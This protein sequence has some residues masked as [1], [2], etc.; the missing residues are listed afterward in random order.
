MHVYLNHSSDEANSE[1]KVEDLP[2]T[3]RGKEV[4]S[5]VAPTVEEFRQTY[6]SLGKT[7][8]EIVVLPISSHLS[9]TLLNAQVAA[10]Q[11]QGRLAVQ[12]ID[13]QTTSVGLG[14]LAQ[15][16]AEAAARQASL[17]EIEHLVR[18][19]IPHIY[20]IFCIPG[21]TYIFRAGFIDY[22]QA[23]VGEML[24]LFP[25][26]TLEDGHL[27]PLEKV[28]NLRHLT[29][30]LQEF[31][32]E[33][34]DLSQISVIQPVPALA[35]EGKSLREHATMSFPKASF[36]ET[37]INLPLASLFGPRSLSVFAIE[38]LDPKQ[39]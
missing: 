20:S 32:D 15:L 18:G 21:L 29:D 30:Y 35:H 23:M 34:T 5:I 16:A 12:I 8:N 31:L 19:Q 11:I 6:L 33:F 27:T 36:N 38:T 3:I 17:S 7:Y 14:Y 28:R 9:S 2:A 37:P 13:S 1:L 4:P 39:K 24:N 25:I 10:A 26:F 22:A